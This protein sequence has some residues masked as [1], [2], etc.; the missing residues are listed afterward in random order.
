MY[1]VIEGTI[2]GDLFEATV[3]PI[4]KWN[5]ERNEMKT[6]VIFLLHKERQ[7]AKPCFYKYNRMIY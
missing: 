7:T 6:D 5:S 2:V 1:V 3:A 4:S